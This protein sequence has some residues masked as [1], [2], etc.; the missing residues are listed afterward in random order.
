MQYVN[1]YEACG[2]TNPRHM[3]DIVA[4]APSEVPAQELAAAKMSTG[5]VDWGDEQN[6][7]HLVEAL[8][9]YGTYAPLWSGTGNNRQKLLKQARKE[10]DMIVMLFGFYMDRTTNILGATGWDR[11]KGEV[12]WNL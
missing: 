5:F 8:A 4:I 1:M 12:G 6:P 9:D 3:V 10:A 7:L 2:E 11:I